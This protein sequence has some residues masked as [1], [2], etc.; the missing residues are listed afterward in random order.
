MTQLNQIIA[1]EKGVKNRAKTELTQAYQKLSSKTA[2]LAGIARSYKPID[3]QGEK[4]PP[5]STR[6]QIK[7]DEIIG[8]VTSQLTRLF[9]VTLT[10]DIANGK[11]RADIQIGDR[12]IAANVP[13][14]YLLF[15]EKELTDIL[16]FVSKL[17]VLD[18]G[19]EWDY[20]ATVDAYATPPSQ[21]V[22]TKKIPRNHTKW[23]P[24]DATFVQPAQVEVFTEDVVVGYW[25]T[26]KFSGALPRAT[27]N[28]IQERVTSLIEAVKKAREKANTTVV[29]DQRIG[30]ALLD[31]VFSG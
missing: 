17:P 5:E 14:T 25:T 22:K 30:K 3:D 28:A 29:D 21:T 24:P 11:A 2:Q 7:A 10:K 20:D 31:F 12:L 15:L 1:I 18:P 27:V 8:E 6:V 23:A 9:D 26:T 19:E 16:T 4:F 13:V